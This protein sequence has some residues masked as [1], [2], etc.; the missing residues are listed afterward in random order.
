[1]DDKKCLSD[2]EFKIEVLTNLSRI[3][4]KLEHVPSKADLGKVK[5]LTIENKSRLDNHRW[6]LGTFFT[7]L[8]TMVVAIFTKGIK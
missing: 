3:N 2:Q 4:E 6:I 5:G 7:G 1:M 8:L